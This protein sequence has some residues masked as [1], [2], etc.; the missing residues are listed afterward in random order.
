MA[1]KVALI[2]Y[3]ADKTKV[4][5]KDNGKQKFDL[6]QQEYTGDD[7]TAAANDVLAADWR[8]VSHFP[9]GDDVYTIVK[10]Y[11]DFDPPAGH[12]YITVEQ[13]R[14]FRHLQYLV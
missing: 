5:L 11:K 1:K 3:S 9:F 2:P 12:K 4:L 10:A 8:Y 7:Y 13:A 14:A 6:I